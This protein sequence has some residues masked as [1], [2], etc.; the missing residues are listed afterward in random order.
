M[1]YCPTKYRR[2]PEYQHDVEARLTF[3]AICGNPPAYKSPHL[4]SSSRIPNRELAQNSTALNLTRTD[5]NFFGIDSSIA[6]HHA[7]FNNS[8]FTEINLTATIA[9]SSSRIFCPTTSMIINSIVIYTPKYAVSLRHS[10]DRDQCRAQHREPVR[11]AAE[12]SPQLRSAGC[13]LERP[14][15]SPYAT[16]SAF[17][18]CNLCTGEF[19]TDSFGSS[20]SWGRFKEH[21]QDVV[22]SQDSTTD[23]LPPVERITSDFAMVSSPL[24]PLSQLAAPLQGRRA[25]FSAVWPRTRRRDSTKLSG[26]IATLP[27]SSA[28][29][30]A[31]GKNILSDRRHSLLAK[32]WLANLCADLRNR[33]N[34]LLNTVNKANTF[35]DRFAVMSPRLQ[36]GECPAVFPAG[37]NR[38]HPGLGMAVDTSG[39]V[40]RRILILT[41]RDA[42]AV[43]MFRSMPTRSILAIASTRLA[44][45]I[46]H[47]LRDYRDGAIPVISANFDRRKERQS[48]SVREERAP[49]PLRSSLRA[50]AKR[51]T[52]PKDLSGVS[53][54]IRFRMRLL[55][56]ANSHR[57]PRRAPRTRAGLHYTSRKLDF[58]TATMPG[59]P[60]SKARSRSASTGWNEGEL[61]TS[62]SLRDLYADAGLPRH[63]SRRCTNAF[64]SPPLCDAK[65]V[66]A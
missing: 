41:F 9:L 45:R 32:A 1:I 13:H 53:S 29:L 38:R 30:I 58:S 43:G 18:T 54:K 17:A 26:H 24:V 3:T 12:G 36:H 6:S 66:P 65:S 33:Q 15:S 10:R 4:P 21:I 7:N 42:F 37:A 16:N 5:S 60:S 64:N 25:Q 51:N 55:V 34:L 62:A 27:K 49:S 14:V 2:R 50:G 28:P 46:F 39:L 35:P 47:W 63:R 52:F 40:Q 61:I 48:P 22:R 44:K 11:H 59:Q 19:A 20:I 23:P 57:R 8:R 56:E 31:S